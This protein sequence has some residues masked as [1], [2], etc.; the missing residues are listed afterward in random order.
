[1]RSLKQRFHHARKTRRGRI[2]LV[3]LGLVLLSAVGACLFYWFIYRKQIVREQL[4]AT[5][6]RKSN[7]LYRISYDK[8][9]LDEVNGHL[10]VTNLRLNYDST[11]FL[12]LATTGKAPGMLLRILIPKLIISGVKTPR[13]LLGQEL[14]GQYVRLQEPRIELFYTNKGADSLRHTPAPAI[15]QQILGDLNLIKL[16]SVLI[17]QAQILSYRYGDTS[18][19]VRISGADL[20]LHELSIDSVSNEDASRILFSR[21]LLARVNQVSWLSA[22]GRYR[23]QGDSIRLDA[24]SQSASIARF[25]IKPLL[26]EAAFTRSLRFADDRFEADIRD[27]EFFRVR[28]NS[29]LNDTLH[30]DSV[31]VSQALLQIYRD[32][33]LPH[34]GKNRVGTYPHQ[35]LLRFG[36]ATRID[37]LKIETASINYKERNAGTR[38]AGIVSFQHTRAH[39]KHLSNIKEYAREH[40]V[41]QVRIQTQFLNRAQLQLQWNFYLFH[42]KGQFTVTGELS[43]MPAAAVNVLTEPMG[44]ARMEKGQINNLQ[45][46]FTG[47]NYGMYGTVRML[48]EDLKVSL[49]EKETGSG[50]LSKKKLA[51]LAANIIIRK[52]NPADKKGNIRTAKVNMQRDT[53]RSIFHLSWKSLFQGIKRTVG[54]NK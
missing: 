37:A 11:R 53:R 54:I 33:G 49:L 36:L 12:Q 52:S 51:S 21:Q 2:I 29:L 39:V 43:S 31:I 16:D 28:F 13:A 47:H 26:N 25:A 17:N 4:E 14:I 24:S 3:V 6:I 42:P 5:V 45:F 27:L 15:Y 38:M 32:L 35:A 50:E 10:S 44:P 9:V 19:L 8:L 40:P 18:N 48:Y 23:L 7:G 41:M 30:A 46:N 22:D 20:H 34:D 1:M